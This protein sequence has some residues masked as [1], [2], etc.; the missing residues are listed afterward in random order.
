[1]LVRLGIGAPAD[2]EDLEEF[3]QLALSAGAI[4]VAS[5]GG[6][7]D[8]PDPRFFVG[9]G[10]AEEIRDVARAHDAD[11]V[12]FD[13]PLSPSQERNLEKLVDYVGDAVPDLAERDQRTDGDVDRF[14]AVADLAYYLA[15]RVQRR[16]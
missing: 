14:L 5:V 7:R 1:M 4:P 16:E 15:E 10:K 2:P 12:L 13:H 6:R 8:R 3:E 11:V 9:S